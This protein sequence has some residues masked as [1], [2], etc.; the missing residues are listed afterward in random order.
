MNLASA[1]LVLRPRGRLETLDLAFRYVLRDGGGLGRLALSTLLPAFLITA[2]ARALSDWSW[3]VIW[4][5]ALTLGTL[6]SGVFTVAAGRLLFEREVEAAAILSAYA[7][8]LPAY[9]GALFPSRALIA[10]GTVVVVLGV[11]AWTRFAYVAEAVLLERVPARRALSRSAT[12]AR[13][14]DDTLSVLDFC[15]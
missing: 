3:W 11:V 12:L 10:L 9:L 5:L 14:A 1:R 13:G 6:G 8:R 2:A 4:A 15:F 7:S